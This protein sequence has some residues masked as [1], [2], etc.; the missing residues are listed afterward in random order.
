[1]LV[2]VTESIYV[3]GVVQETKRP[4]LELGTGY[5][6]ETSVENA[7]G[8]FNRRIRRMNEQQDAFRASFKEK[9]QHQEIVVSIINQKL[10]AARRPH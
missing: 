8:F 3:H 4:I 6:V 7:Q 5:F 10:Q 2:P 1:M 9:K